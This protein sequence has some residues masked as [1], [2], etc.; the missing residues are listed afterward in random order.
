MVQKPTHI[1]GSLIAHHCVKSVQIRS[2]FWSV[3]SRNAGK[4]G[5]EKAL[6]LDTFHTVH[7]YI[8]KSLMKAF[9]LNATIENTCFL[10]H[11]Y[12]NVIID[13]RKTLLIFILFH[14]TIDD[15]ARKKN[16]LVS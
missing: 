2:F 11:D 13:Y 3:F 6:Y 15:Q 14:K 12:R 9:F 5:P 16:L 8:K 1:A 7:V 10:D 4:Y